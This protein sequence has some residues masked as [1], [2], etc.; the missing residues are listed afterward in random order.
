VGLSHSF[1]ISTTNFGCCQTD[2]KK[3]KALSAGKF[4]TLI[5]KLQ[6]LFLQEF[7]F[8]E[9]IFLKKHDLISRI[10]ISDW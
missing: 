1:L 2:R 7:I 3:G 5:R 8:S 9:M 6:I 10:V 4:A